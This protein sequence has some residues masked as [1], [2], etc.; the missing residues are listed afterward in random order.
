MEHELSVSCKPYMGVMMHEAT[1]K[2]CLQAASL[3]RPQCRP[4]RALAGQSSGPPV[5][6]IRLIAS[7]VDGTLL[8]SRQELTP[9]VERAVALANSVGVPVPT[10][11][12]LTTQQ[13]AASA[14]KLFNMGAHLGAQWCCVWFPHTTQQI[15]A[16]MP[17]TASALPVACPG[18]G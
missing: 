10:L 17:A 13:P 3:C 6:E 9:G 2:A 14:C 16:C 7:D 8:N 5:P 11:R 18:Q 4:L 1:E 12:F 15:T